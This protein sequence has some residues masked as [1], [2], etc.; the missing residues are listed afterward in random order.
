MLSQ[1]VM[2][3]TLNLYSAIYVSYILIQPEEKK[4]NS[5][6]RKKEMYVCLIGVIYKV[7]LIS[8]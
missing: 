6:T 3:Y 1:T 5:R 7:N 4:L 2:L 8:P